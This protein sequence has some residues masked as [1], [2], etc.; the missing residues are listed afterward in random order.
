MIDLLEISTWESVASQILS[1]KR[2]ALDLEGD[3]NLYR[4]GRRICLFQIALDDGS[5]F[6]LD[7]LEQGESTTQHWEGWKDFLEDPARTKIIWAAQNDIRVLK[8]C[9]Q[10]RLRGLWDLFDAAALAV[11][12]RPSLPFLLQSLLGI[13]IKKESSLQTSDWNRRPLLPEQQHYAAQDVRFLLPLADTLTA[14][15]EE[16]P[17]KNTV[18]K[19]RMLK[20]EDYEFHDVPEPWR[21][22]KGYVL[23]DEPQREILAS[24]WQS[25]EVL[26]RTLDLAPWRLAPHEDL[27]ERVKTGS[28]PDKSRIDPHWIVD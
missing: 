1:Q 15:L 8:A 17:A 27:V 13:E 23:L 5:I 7:P 24:L 19:K 9:H 2:V 11:T 26:A 20:A 6:L 18:F 28:W 21:R 4:Y 14:L 16:Q 22:W 10:T 3:F 25:R 12:P